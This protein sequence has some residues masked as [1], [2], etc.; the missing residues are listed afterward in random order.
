[1]NIVLIGLHTSILKPSEFSEN[2]TYYIYFGFASILL[3]YG[4]ETAFFRFYSQSK[5]KSTI[6]STVSISLLITTAIAFLGVFAFQNS[7]SNHLGI[8]SFR[9]RLL[10]IMLIVETLWVVPFA[11]YRIKG[12]AKKFT[13]TKLLGV[14][15]YV[16]LNFY[17]LKFVPLYHIN[18]PNFLKLAPVD[19]VFFANML[20]SVLTFILVFPVYFQQK[21]KFDITIIKEMLGYS[22][23][24]LVAGIAF[25]I[26]E[27]IDKLV[28]KDQLGKGV[29]G[30]YAAC[31]KLAMFLTLFIQA[32][33]MGVEP[34]FFS[35]SES[36]NAPQTYATVMK[37]YVIFASLG[38]LFVIVFI[39]EFKLLM[40]RDSSYWHALSIVP[41]IL[42]ANWCL[43]AYHSLSVWYKITDRT[44]YAMWFSIVGAIITLIINYAFIPQYGFMVAAW[45]TL[46]A[47][48]SMM[49]LSYFTGRK[50]YPIPYDLKSILGYLI[51][52]LSISMTVYINFRDI[53]WVKI[54]AVLIFLMTIIIFEQKSI[55]PMLK[56]QK[57]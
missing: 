28:L 32:F 31:Y 36:K 16:I 18:L 49:L 13:I 35:Q 14:F 23:P 1:M 54:L 57:I 52:A 19:Y 29:M 12:W 43:G 26:N 7:V 30:A 41:I 55:L 46:A 48:G 24:I 2:A 4:M 34:F 42:L 9:L 15:L 5:S 22:W 44:R 20:S 47:Y 37:F 27:N 25:M 40:I 8:S 51:I 45:A 17:F 56:K 50:K 10:S 33:R 21:W 3:T 39:D 6:I 38:L 53:L 11:Y